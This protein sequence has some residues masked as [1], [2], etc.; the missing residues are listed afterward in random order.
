MIL[1]K[2]NKMKID[3]VVFKGGWVCFQV[4]RMDDRVRCPFDVREYDGPLEIDNKQNEVFFVAS[5][6]F[7]IKSSTNRGHPDFAP[8]GDVIYICGNDRTCDGFVARKCFFTEEKALT[9]VDRAKVAVKELGE[10]LDK[11][12]ESVQNS[13]QSFVAEF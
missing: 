6:G 9:F 12:N 10:F 13:P 5:N 7:M 3:F 4:S 8:V 11:H 1:E 2:E